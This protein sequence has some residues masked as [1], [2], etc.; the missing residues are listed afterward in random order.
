VRF[1]NYQLVGFESRTTISNLTA[2][3]RRG[4]EVLAPTKDVS[5]YA[6]GR[7]GEKV[8]G[9]LSGGITDTWRLVWQRSDR[10]EP[11]YLRWRCP[12]LNDPQLGEL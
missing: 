3:K 2:A 4:T 6:L 10:F 1:D 12:V 9:T 11:F 8:D 7:H 5:L